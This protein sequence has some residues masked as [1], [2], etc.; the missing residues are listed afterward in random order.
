MAI[1]GAAP[2]PDALCGGHRPRLHRWCAANRSS[3]G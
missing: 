1:E 2:A 3:A